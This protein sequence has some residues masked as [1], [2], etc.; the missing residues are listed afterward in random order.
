M[1][2]GEIYWVNLDPTIGEEIKKRRPVIVLNGGHEKHLRLAIVVPITAWN[3]NWENNPFF[4]TLEPN[5]TNRLRKKSV[6]DCFQMRAISHNRFA[7]KIGKISD[8][9]TNLLK[10]SIALILDI[11]P[12]HCE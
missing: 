8:E 9:E 2:V 7:E 5:S 1:K 10:E 3:V 12:E 11:E 6:V 4:I